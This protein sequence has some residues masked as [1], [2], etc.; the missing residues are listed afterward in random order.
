MFVRKALYGRTPQ[1]VSH[2]LNFLQP[3]GIVM[4]LLSYVGR[5][6]SNS[7]YL[8]LRKCLKNLGDSERIMDH[9][10]KHGPAVMG[11]DAS[12]SEAVTSWIEAQAF[13]RTPVFF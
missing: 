10:R 3:R 11:R 4:E 12:W 5:Y 13:E 2:P 8:K 9:E 1:E 7:F 6:F